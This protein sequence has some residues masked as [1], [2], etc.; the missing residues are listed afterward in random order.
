MLFLLFL[1]LEH[2]FTFPSVKQQATSYTLFGIYPDSSINAIWNPASVLDVNKYWLDLLR[3]KEHY[4]DFVAYRTIFPIINTNKTCLGGMVSLSEE[5]PRRNEL[6]EHNR[7]EI[8]FGYDGNIKYGTSIFVDRKDWW[9]RYPW[10]EGWNY[11]LGAKLGFIFPTNTSL[12]II[13][14]KEDT[15]EAFE[16]LTYFSHA[17]PNYGV[18]FLLSTLPDNKLNFVGAYHINHLQ[19]GSFVKAIKIEWENEHI[20]YSIPLVLDFNAFKQL[21]LYGG[22][23]I[24]IKY[25][26]KEVEADKFISMGFTYKCSPFTATV[27]M[28]NHSTGFFEPFNTNY[29]EVSLSYGD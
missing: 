1:S 4:R 15:A 24:Q 28:G 22:Y 9:Y 8:F 14:S 3:L 17:S 26:E 11:I 5:A 18:A 16:S 27:S 21:S 29:W 13:T 23:T 20:K 25:F 7:G 6:H 12:S 19:R 10:S 2:I